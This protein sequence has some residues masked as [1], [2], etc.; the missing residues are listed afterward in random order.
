MH[1]A[2]T[3]K[4]SLSTVVYKLTDLLPHNFLIYKQ[5]EYVKN[6][7]KEKKTQIPQS[8]SVSLLIGPT[9]NYVK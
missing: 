3:N 1:N 7:E 8:L 2:V 6:I 9:V 4:A 5:V